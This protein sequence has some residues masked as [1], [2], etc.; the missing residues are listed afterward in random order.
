MSEDDYENRHVVDEA[1]VWL[2]IHE[3]EQAINSLKCDVKVSYHNVPRQL[4][5]VL[6][7][8][9]P[10]GQ[11]ETSSTESTTRWYV[12]KRGNTDTTYFLKNE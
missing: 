10:N 2:V 5:D 6:K 12:L 7:Y 4:F 3:A 1:S 11:Y 9:V 8:I